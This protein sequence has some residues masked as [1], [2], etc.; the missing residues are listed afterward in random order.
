MN[1]EPVTR[2]LGGVQLRDLPDLAI[3][4]ALAAHSWARA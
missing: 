3:D 4:K 2:L 1:G